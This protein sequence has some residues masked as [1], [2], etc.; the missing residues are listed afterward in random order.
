MRLC[1]CLLVGLSLV[2]S[3]GAIAAPPPNYHLVKTIKV[4]GDGGWDCLTFDGAAK[5]LYI[6]RSSR[7]QVVDVEKGVL[8]GEVANTQGVHGV[9]L[10]P[11]MN[12][13]YASNGQDNSVTVFDLATLKE[14]ERIKV[15]T[16]PDVI[17]F[18]PKTNRV[19]VF[20]G[21]SNDATAIDVATNKVAGTVPL[22]GKPE[23]AVADGKGL[24]FVNIEDTSEIAS[25]DAN[26]LKVGT[27][28]SLAPGESPSGLAIDMW[29]RRLF[30][31]CS[32]QQMV[33]S[34]AD[35][36]K[37]VTTA[38]IGRGPDGAGFYAK[39]GLAFSSNGQDGTLSVVELR[40]ARGGVESTS[41]TRSIVART[42]LASVETV[43][44]QIS[45]RTMA[46][47]PMTGKV[48]LAAAKYLPPA[49]GQ[50]QG[51]RRQIEPDSFVVLVFAP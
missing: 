13:G 31:V 37:V 15:G 21:G 23:F 12:R 3:V 30:S 45:A 6:A 47:D 10:V 34:D 26:A 29:N 41:A 35:S 5:R 39:L 20:N 1:I 42:W 46:L 4:G 14:T 28:W 11:K 22:G 16:K 32:N 9:A 40:K 51:R 18:D 2:L 38:P 17:I 43:P 48:Y 50:T 7:V 24:I 36:G 49:P 25:F 33:V 27:R 8:A 19:F 44:T